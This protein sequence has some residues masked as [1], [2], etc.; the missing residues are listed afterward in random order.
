[1][2]GPS[3][4][5]AVVYTRASFP[6]FDESPL[7]ALVT[8][9]A[10]PTAFR[11]TPRRLRRGSG[12]AGA[13]HDANSRTRWA[14]SVT[15]GGNPTGYVPCYYVAP[16]TGLYNVA[17]YGPNGNNNDADGTVGADVA[18]TSPRT[19]ARCKGR[20]PPHGISQFATISPRHGRQRPGLHLRLG[21]IY[22]QQRRSSDSTVYA[23]TLD[24]MSTRRTSLARPQRFRLL[25]S[26]QGS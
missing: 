23:T 14:P 2:N 11:V 24:V 17:F 16:T 25:R 20:P 18:L 26:E 21:R 13:A 8:S 1:M 10:V 19:P 4:G 6:R 5:D 15:G 7:P 12:R 3:E 22:R 9:G